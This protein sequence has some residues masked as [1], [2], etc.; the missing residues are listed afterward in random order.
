M[1]TCQSC[2]KENPAD[3]DFCS[4]G[5][6]LRWE[7]TGYMQAITP[8]QAAEAKQET[9]PPPSIPA[10]QQAAPV[11]PETPGNGHGNGHAAPPPPPPPPLPG[12]I[13]AAGVTCAA[14]G[15]GGGAAGG[16]GSGSGCFGGAACAAASAAA[17]GVMACM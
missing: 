7:P 17:S 5:E 3:Q 1:R 2:G 14:A 15:G 10:V 9:E 12:V 16:A 11:V 8:E 4:C 13:G 6:Y